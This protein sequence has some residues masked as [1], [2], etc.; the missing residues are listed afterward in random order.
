MRIT[1]IE[2]KH[3]RG[4]PGPGIYTFDLHSGKNLLLYGENGSGKSS[5]F[6]ALN[7]MFSAD[8][9]AQPFAD[10]ANLFAR[11]DL[12]HEITDGFVTVYL[13]SRPATVLTWPQNGPHP[14]GDFV[15]DAAMRKGFLEYRSLLRTNFVDGILEERLFLLAVEVLLARIPVP[16]GGTSRMLGEYWSQVTT[17]TNHRAKT[18]RAAEAA[19][20]L[21]NAAFSSILPDVETKATEILNHFTGNHLRLRLEAD[22][23]LYDRHERRIRNQ[24]LRVN[25][26]YNGQP[27]PRYEVILNEARLSALALAL[28]LSSVLLSNPAPGPAVRSPLKLL[29]LDDVLIGLDLANRMPLLQILDCHFS[30]YQIILCTF[31]QVWYELARLDTQAT[32]RWVCAELF[33]DRIGNPG[34]DVP[35][36]KMGGRSCIDQAWAHFRAH[37]YCAASVYARAAFETR[38]MNFCEE[39]SLPVRYYKDPRR[40]SSE[41]LWKAVTGVKGGDGLCHVDPATKAKIEALRKVVL[42][43]LSHANASSIMS[44]EVDAAIRAV[45]GLHIT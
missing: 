3:F 15:F 30:D 1:K 32:N 9:H 8:G 17:P 13:D 14:D 21:F 42:N 45:E 31:D 34:Y 26:E 40:I 4:F 11:D 12:G 37:D 19:I 33:A 38:L 36:L 28:Y 44:A 6:Q 10:F 29:V 39:K 24:A 5:L 22:D 27:L 43:P 16:L 41:D 35:V 2:I 23:L 20:D 25:V 18:L 7:Q